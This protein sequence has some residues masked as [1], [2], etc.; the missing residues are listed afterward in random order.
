MDFPPEKTSEIKPTGTEESKV[1]NATMDDSSQKKRV[2]PDFDDV[3][4]LHF[5]TNSCLATC[6]KL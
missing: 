2:A 4:S 1:L 5:T 6:Q 3:V